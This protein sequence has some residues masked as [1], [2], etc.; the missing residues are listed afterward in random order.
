MRNILERVLRPFTQLKN[1]VVDYIFFKIHLPSSSNASFW[2]RLLI[3][4]SV[5]VLILVVILMPLDAT[6]IC[7]TI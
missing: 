3:G 2:K 7:F 6:Y 5:T 1:F 4:L